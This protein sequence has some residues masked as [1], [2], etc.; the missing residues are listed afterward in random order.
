MLSVLG[1]FIAWCLGWA[2]NTLVGVCKL[3][4]CMMRVYGIAFLVS[5]GPVVVRKKR[6]RS[7]AY[8]EARAMKPSVVKRALRHCEVCKQEFGGH[9]P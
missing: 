5:H 7:K 8:Y 3:G 6:I 4:W 9:H 2:F 1:I